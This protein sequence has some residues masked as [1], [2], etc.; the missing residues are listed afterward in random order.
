MLW[1]ALGAVGRL[2]LDVGGL[3][4]MEPQLREAAM[5]AAARRA[6]AE[7]WWAGT[8]GMTTMGLLRDLKGSGVCAQL[9]AMVR[10]GV[11]LGDASAP[12]LALLCDTCRVSPVARARMTASKH[13]APGLGGPGCDMC[14]RADGTVQGWQHWLGGRCP[15]WRDAVAACWA[16]VAGEY[17][18]GDWEAAAGD[19][20]WVARFGCA[21]A[22]PRRQGEGGFPPAYVRAAAAWALRDGLGAMLWERRE[23]IARLQP[24]LGAGR[25]RG[26]RSR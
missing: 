4:A 20:G 12:I 13:V 19:G 17:T 9:Y 16:A 6:T 1:Q 23:A 10:G 15:V 22:P 25:G 3:L 11:V 21:R 2:G 26:G 8:E 7:E 5:K 24:A 18:E 14:M